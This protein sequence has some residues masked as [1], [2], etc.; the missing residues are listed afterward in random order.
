MPIRYS[1]VVGGSSSSGFNLDI[2]SSG[3]TTFAF[4][5]A[6]PAGGY[7]IT[8]QLSDST[9]EFY[10]IAEDGTLAGYSSSKALSA[11]KD[12]DRIVVYG[13][14]PNDLITFE[15]KETTLPATSGDQD[16]G[17]APFI[18]S[19]SNADLANIDDSTIVTGG[20]FANNVVVTFTGTD[21]ISRNPKSVVRTNSTQLIVTRP[22]N[23][24][25]DDAPYTLEVSNPGIPQSAYAT[26][27]SSLTAGGD[28]VWVTSDAL[29]DSVVG[30][31]YSFTIEATDPDNGLISYSVVSALPTGLSLNSSSGEISGAPTNSGSFSFVISA[32]DSS[33]NITNK[34]FSLEVSPD[35]VAG[36]DVVEQGGYK[37]HT[38]TS[39]G[40]LTVYA[41]TSN[42]EYLVVAGGG[43]GGKDS[44]SSNRGSG[45]GGAG[46]YR[47]SVIGELSGENS[48]AESTLSLTAGQY[49]ITVGAGGAAAPGTLNEDVRGF[50]GEDSSIIGNGIDI[51]SLGGGGAGGHNTGG[52]YPGRNGGSGGGGGN[53]QVA[54]SGTPGQGFGGGSSV[55][56]SPYAGSGGGGAGSASSNV[57][58]NIAS[59]GGIGIASSITGTSVYRA[60]G[61]GGHDAYNGGAG[62]DGGGGAGGGG[63]SNGS[64]G[65]EYSGGGG[66]GSRGTPGAGGSG[67]VIVRYPI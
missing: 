52:A 36:G 23:F 22:D 20:N 30:I 13:A 8:S 58:G 39:N 42:I 40:T 6:Q 18:T 25:E 27:T 44:F 28:P 63:S 53:G 17:A 59:A 31:A 21:N 37:I 45:G 50:S 60:G 64:S 51:T 16:S 15:F 5:E 7:S 33:G 26:T 29:P 9:I 67:I 49:A 66:G 47:S 24:L 2:G 46:G 10:A 56:V 14:T 12:F 48:T 41:T 38:F 57:T 43:G 34:S 62:G 35:L 55:N 11:S 4:S 61:G 3:N 19:V 54:S 32:T 65:Q 1:S